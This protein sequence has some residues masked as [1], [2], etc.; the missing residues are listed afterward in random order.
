MR[1]KSIFIFLIYL[2][3]FIL[4]PIIKN[5]TRL[6]EKKIESFENKIVSLE[7]NLIEA[8]LEFQYLSSAENLYKTINKNLDLKYE[9]LDV[10][11]IYSSL[12]AFINQQKQL[13][14]ISTNETQTK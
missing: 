4:I 12:E 5:E 8:S 14:K 3:F 9:S 7:K 6:I 1:N 13:S 10:S 2:S 11:Q